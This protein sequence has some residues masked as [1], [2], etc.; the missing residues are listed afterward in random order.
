MQPQNRR[1]KI[2]CLGLHAE[3]SFGLLANPE[4]LSRVGHV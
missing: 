1:A 3:D 2:H 4:L